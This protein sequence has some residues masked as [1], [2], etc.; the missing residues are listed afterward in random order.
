MEK[1]FCYYT[2]FD[3]N[4]TNLKVIDCDPRIRREILQHGHEK[5][6]TAVPVTEQQHHA[7]EVEDAHEHPSYAQKLSA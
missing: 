3:F 4:F 2:V 6:Q 7:D 1:F 5:L